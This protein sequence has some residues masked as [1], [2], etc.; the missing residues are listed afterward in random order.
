MRV[1]GSGR[2][3]IR[4]R[5]E[6]IGNPVAHDQLG[7]RPHVQLGTEFSRHPSTTTTTIVFCSVT[8][9]TLVVISNGAVTS[10]KSVS[11][12]AIEI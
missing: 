1:R 5:A 9:S 12:F 10:N 11:S 2:R 7:R 6:V 4:R 3:V 8:S